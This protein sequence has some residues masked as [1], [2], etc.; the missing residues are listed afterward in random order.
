VLILAWLDVAYPCSSAA[1]VDE[2]LLARHNSTNRA[3]ELMEQYMYTCTGTA[4]A[5]CRASAQHTADTE[6]TRRHALG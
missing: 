4:A 5:A 6:L 2:S 3:T 1:D